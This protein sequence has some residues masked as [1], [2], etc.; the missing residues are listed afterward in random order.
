MSDY[1]SKINDIMFKEIQH[2]QNPSFLEFGV[3]EGRS[4][5]IFLD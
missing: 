5:K 1:I 3:K 4:T 2:I